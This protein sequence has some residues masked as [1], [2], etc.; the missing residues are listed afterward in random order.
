ML[1][2]LGH[3]FSDSASKKFSSGT[4]IGGGKSVVVGA[5]FLVGGIFCIF[6]GLSLNCCSWQEQIRGSSVLSIL[7]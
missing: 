3:I 4:E 5:I 6:L 7:N 1:P 2:P